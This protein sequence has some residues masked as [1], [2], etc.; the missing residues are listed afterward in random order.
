MA[1][2]RSSAFIRATS[3]ASQTNQAPAP[4]PTEKETTLPPTPNTVSSSTPETVPHDDL[5]VKTSFYP[6]QDQLE[7]LDDL[8][9]EY[10]KRYRR[11]RKKIDRQDIVRHLI[12]KCDLDALADLQI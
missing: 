12:D 11:Q 6:R 4:T 2:Q 8:A 5:V 3:E 1:K 10:N 7:K 9:S